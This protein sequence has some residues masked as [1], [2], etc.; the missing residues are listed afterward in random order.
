L[1]GIPWTFNELDGFRHSKAL[2]TDLHGFSKMNTDPQTPRL[3]CIC[4]NP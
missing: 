2:A 4:A 3:V 1:P